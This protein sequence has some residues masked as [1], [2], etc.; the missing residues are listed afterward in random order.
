MGVPNALATRLAGSSATGGADANPGWR[1]VGSRGTRSSTPTAST[2]GLASHQRRVA[3]FGISTRPRTSSQITSTTASCTTAL[4]RGE[5]GCG[6][7]GANRAATPTTT[8][9]CAVYAHN[10]CWPSGISTSPAPSAEG[11]TSWRWPGK[12]SEYQRRGDESAGALVCFGEG[13][14]QQPHAH[15][16]CRGHARRVQRQPPDEG[17]QSQVRPARSAVP[18]AESASRKPRERR[19]SKAAIPGWWNPTASEVKNSTCQAEKWNR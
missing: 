13:R 3:G 17:I 15:L 8:R 16:E 5:P 19:P 11:A 7:S 12:G 9:M 1:G 14:L 4:T 6:M 10:A 2:A 18:S